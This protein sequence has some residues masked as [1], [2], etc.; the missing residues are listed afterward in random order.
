MKILVT[1]G[2]GFVGSHA[3]EALVRAGHEVRLLA[4]SPE[5]VDRVMATRRIEGLDV[6]LGDM[7]DA[8][9]VRAA[10][11]GCDA[12]LHAAAEVEIGR[13]KDVFQ[14]NVAGS[15]NVLGTAVELGLDPVLVISSIAT[16]FPPTGSAITVDDPIVNLSSDYGRSKAEGERYARALQ[17]AGKPVVSIYPSAVT[18]PDDPGPSATVKGLRDAIRFGYLMT[19]G[20]VGRV[21]VRDLATVVVA[22]LEPGRGPRRYMAGGR[23]LPWAEEAALC[24]QIIGRRVRR[25]TAP[26]WAVRLVGRTVDAIKAVMPSFDYPLTYEASLF[27]TR[28]VPCDDQKTTEELGVTFRA[29][30]ETLTD[31]IRFLLE[32]AELEPSQAPALSA[33]KVSAG[34][35]S[36]IR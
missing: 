36:E 21:D 16:M 22:A 6:V 8:A 19:S 5:K 3:V 20:G 14:S 10:L 18:G 7:T 15:H 31:T 34:S 1:G 28:M 25:I 2:T 23:F 33:P 30:R 24:E 29:S 27:M 32:A 13:A 35:P 11:I 4:R 26:P 17:A 12:V 9:R